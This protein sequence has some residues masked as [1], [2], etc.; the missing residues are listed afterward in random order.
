MPVKA[1]KAPAAA[2]SPWDIAFGTAFTTDY[3]L[4]GVSQSNRKPA[5][6]GYFEVDYT[7]TTWLT[8]YAGSLGLEPV[9]GLRQRRNRSLRRR[10][11]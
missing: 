7:A 2:P 11:L 8:L 3:I 10:A 4:R 9:T 6:Q 5:V 1:M